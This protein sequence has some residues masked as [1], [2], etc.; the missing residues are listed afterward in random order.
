MELIK[1]IQL[2]MELMEGKKFMFGI[3]HPGN[4]R[5]QLIKETIESLQKEL[6]AMKEHPEYY[7][8]NDK[9]PWFTI[10]V[11]LLK[12]QKPQGL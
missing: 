6:K 4:D 12:V 5:E 3:S 9:D 10:N 11:E 8:E 7:V 2:S 1:E